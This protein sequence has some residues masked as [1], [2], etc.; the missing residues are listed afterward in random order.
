M[1]IFSFS[2]LSK[3]VTGTYIC[4]CKQD[5]SHRVFHTVPVICWY[6]SN[7]TKALKVIEERTI[8]QVSR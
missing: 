8:P 7:A 4:M 6:G 3:S 1:S 5:G 2:E